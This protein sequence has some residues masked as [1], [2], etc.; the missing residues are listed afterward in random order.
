MPEQHRH[1][2]N[3]CED[4]VNLQGVE[5]YCVATRTAF[6]FYFQHSLKTAQPTVAGQSSRFSEMQ[7]ALR[8]QHVS[9]N[10]YYYYYY[11]Y[12]Y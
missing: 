2:A 12:Y 1:L 9:L 7:G 8:A 10:N 4:I 11:Y 5:A 6:Y 3:N